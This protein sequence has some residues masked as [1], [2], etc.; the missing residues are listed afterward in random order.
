MVKSGEGWTSQRWIK[1]PTV[2][3][4]WTVSLGRRAPL[5]PFQQ[6]FVTEEKQSGKIIIILSGKTVSVK[7]GHKQQAQQ[8]IEKTCSNFL[9]NYSTS[10]GPSIATSTD[11]IT[12]TYE[13]V[14]EF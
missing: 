11:K 3:F 4:K 7:Q 8:I 13:I 12:I 2:H 10:I 5:E 1:L 14:N 6:A 9:V